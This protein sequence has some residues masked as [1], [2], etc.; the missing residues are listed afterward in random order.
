MKSKVSALMDGELDQQDVSNI[1]E[2]IK[3]DN[4][5]RDEWKAYHVIGD[6]LRQSSRLSMNISAS[7]NQKL[8][9]EPTILSPHNSS[10][11]VEKK[12]THKVLAFSMAA[13]VIAMVSGWVIMNNLYNPQQ[14]MV[15]EQSK[16][17]NN[18]T[19]TPITVS[20]PPLIHNYS[21]PPVE[22]NDYL[23][24]HREFSPGITMN[25]QV[26]NVNNVTEYHERYGR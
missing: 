11:N 13:S 2:A 20:S 23:F 21:H 15:A 18:L 19:T 24:V 14:V 10:R 8:K 5:L 1:I 12:Q 7:V 22:M 17:D 4:D 26:T 9:A 16:R 3:K 6:A 25:G